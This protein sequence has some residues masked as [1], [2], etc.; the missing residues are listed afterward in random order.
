MDRLYD[1]IFVRS[2]SDN[3]A[4]CESS[5]PERD[6]ID[7]TLAKRQHKNYVSILKEVKNLRVIELPPLYDLPDS[8]FATDP[9]I[10]GVK[11]CTV[12]RFGLASRRRENQ[13]LF[14]DLL[15]YGDVVGKIR[16]VEEPG[17]LEG[18]DILVT[19]NQIFVGEST[20]SNLQGM[21]QL[22]KY[23]RLRVQ[24]IRSKTFHLLCGC[25]YLDGRKI[26]LAPSLLSPK[27]FPGFEFVLVPAD[28]TYA[29]EAL[30]LGE[31]K[32]M[33]PTGYPKTVNHL[34]RA[35]YRPIEIDISEF[36]KGDGGISCLSAPVYKTL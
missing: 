4:N 31:N 25:S 6:S 16:R 3:Y 32:V 35:G 27:L 28:E 33:M 11:T 10:L 36:W 5:N 26:L 29:A 23:N 14:D 24:P 21:Q 15:N 13:A 19:R 18:G 34:R 2:P 20:R 9:A 22:A 12:C 8:V 7:V 1:T 30:H 17:T